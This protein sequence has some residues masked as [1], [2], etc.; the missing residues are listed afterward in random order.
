[1]NDP[2]VD[3]VRRIRDAKIWMP[4]SRHKERKEERRIPQ[5]VARQPVLTQPLQPTEAT[6]SVAPASGD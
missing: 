2:I 1:M 5:G 3:Q 6:S 4:F